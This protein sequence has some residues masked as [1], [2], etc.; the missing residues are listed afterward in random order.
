MKEP[1]EDVPPGLPSKEVPPA[2]PAPTV[3]ATV[4]II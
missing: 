3:T 2:P 1:K 4:P